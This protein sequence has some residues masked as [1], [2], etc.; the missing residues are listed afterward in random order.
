MQDGGRSKSDSSAPGHS[1]GGGWQTVLRRWPLPWAR[2]WLHWVSSAAIVTAVCS[3]L[4]DFGDVTTVCAAALIWVIIAADGVTHARDKRRVRR[5]RESV[6]VASFDQ[7]SGFIEKQSVRS[8]VSGQDHLD[9]PRPMQPIVRSYRALASM[10]VLRY[11]RDRRML[12]LLLTI[13][14]LSTGW[15]QKR[16]LRYRAG[17]FHNEDWDKRARRQKLVHAARVF[18][19]TE[20]RSRV[21]V[22]AAP[23]ATEEDARSVLATIEERRFQQRS[24]AQTTDETEVVAP[25][26]AG[27]HARAWLIST[28]TP[29]GALRTLNVLWT[30]PGPLLLV[31]NYSAPPEVD[32]YKLTAALI[33]RERERLALQVATGSG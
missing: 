19:N 13:D 21:T 20:T 10:L 28:V 16:E 27:E 6:S 9:A 12:D 32:I 25:A 11:S 2:P 33:Q 1:R 18:V 24:T 31:I 5:L 26:E 3:L 7:V 8:P 17:I 23:Y 4:F 15:R 30:E 14:D 29:K 22:G